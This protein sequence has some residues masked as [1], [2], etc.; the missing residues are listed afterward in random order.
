MAE[1]WRP[2]PEYEGYYEASADG[3]IRRSTPFTS[4][5]ARRRARVLTS[6][7]SGG[8]L[9]V[10]LCRDGEKRDWYVHRL[11]ALAFLGPLPGGHGVNHVDGDKRNNAAANLESATPRENIRHA[12]GLGLFPTG[13]RHNRATVFS[14]TVVKIRRLRGEGADIGEIA[15]LYGL[16]RDCVRTIVTRR[17]W[18]YVA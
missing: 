13:D 3:R 6:H 1:D 2:I 18:K 5:G 12:I 14:E 7:V 15:R 16:T 8:Y 9:R 11:V 17:S 4:R 10:I